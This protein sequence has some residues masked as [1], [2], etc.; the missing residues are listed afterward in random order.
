MIEKLA[1][2]DPDRIKLCRQV[3]GR[4]IKFHDYGGHI[5]HYTLQSRGLKS[6]REKESLSGADAGQAPGNVAIACSVVRDRRNAVEQIDDRGRVQ[7]VVNSILGIFGVRRKERPF[8][9]RQDD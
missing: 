1:E 2:D 7:K 6:R 8:R 4:D 3:L 5:W 9:S